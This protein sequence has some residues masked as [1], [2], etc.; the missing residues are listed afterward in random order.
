M[1]KKP[2]D[3]PGDFRYRA[4]ALDVVKTASSAAHAIYLLTVAIRH[5]RVI[6]YIIAYE[7]L[8][9]EIQKGAERVKGRSNLLRTL[10]AY[11]RKARPTAWDRILDAPLIGNDTE[12]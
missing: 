3:L 10:K 4:H 6:E 7:A 1:R 5:E 12:E 8:Q 2:K 9:E 11:T